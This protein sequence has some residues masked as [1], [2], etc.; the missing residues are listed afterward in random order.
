MGQGGCNDFVADGT[1]ALAEHDP[2]Q[3]EP[4]ADDARPSH[5]GVAP[6]TARQSLGSSG[7]HP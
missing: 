6:Y 4:R 1:A 7:A 2:I 5:V 3:P